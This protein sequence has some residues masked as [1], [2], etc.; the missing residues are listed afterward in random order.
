[1]VTDITQLDELVL[2][3]YS[4]QKREDQRKEQLK[5]NEKLG[6][7]KPSPKFENYKNYSG[8]TAC[9]DDF[10]GSYV[11]IDV[12]ATWCVPCIVEMPYMRKIEE[13]YAKKI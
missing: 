3:G 2:I 6:K 9:L 1:M 5:I 4:E 11:Y 12:W 13:E 10:E 8:G 7:G